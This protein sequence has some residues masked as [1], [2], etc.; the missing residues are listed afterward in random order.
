MEEGVRLDTHCYG[1]YSIP[2][3]YDSLIA[4]LIVRGT[5]RE[6]AIQKTRRA[7]EEFLIEGIHTTVPFHR[8]LLGHRQFASGKYDI[9]FVE[10]EFY[11]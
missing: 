10:D 11:R 9:R 3:Y 4:K 8:K 2:P 7:L 6:D 1:G 5:N